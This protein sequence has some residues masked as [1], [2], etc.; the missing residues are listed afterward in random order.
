MA[1]SRLRA[2]GVEAGVALPAL[3]LAGG[4]VTGTFSSL[5]A[6]WPL[7]CLFPCCV[8]AGISWRFARP[9][10]TLIP[11]AAGF[12]AAG[13]AL[14]ADARHRAVHAPLRTLLHERFG[15]FAIETPGPA[16]DHDPVG[17][18]VLLT[19]DAA[20]RDGFVS[21]RG[22]VTAVEIDGGVHAV[23]GGASF[24][25]GGALAGARVPEWRAGR[26][27]RAWATFGRPARYLN[28]GVPD[29]ERGL[30]LD[31][32]TLFGSVKSGLLVDVVSRGSLL[33]EAAADARAHVRQVVARRVAPHDLVSAGIVTAVLIG[34][35]TGLPDDVRERLQKAG[36]YHVIAISGGNIA[37]LAAVALAA[38]ALL[39]VRGRAAAVLAIVVLLAYAQVVTAGPSVWRA[40]LMAVLYFTA[41]ALDHET[42]SWHVT[43]IAAGLM[44]TVEPLD[45]RDPGFILTFGATVALIEG[46][47]RGSAFGRRHRA[48]AWLLAS[49]AA[50]LATEAALLPVS[51]Q[52]FSR[53]TSAGVVLNLLAVP[54]MVVVQCAGMVAVFLDRFDAV[55]SAA[56]MV[57]YGAASALVGSARLVD[58]VPWLAVRVPPPG[59]VLL[60]VYYG[61]LVLVLSTRR[62][63]V[64]AAGAMMLAAA[65]L[66]IASGVRRPGPL[67]GQTER[68]VLRVTMFDVG[69]AEAMLLQLPDGRTLLVDAGGAPFGRGGF[70]IGARVLAP[71]LWA[72]GVRRLEAMLVTHGHPD[73]MGGARTLVEVFSPREL[74]EGVR[75]PED[76]PT[77]ELRDTA[78]RVGS[79]VVS[80]R[81]G[82]RVMSD[83]VG[84]RVLHPPEPDWERQRVRN[85]DSVVLE[86]LHGDVAF[87]LTGDVAS[88]VERSLLPHLARA[89]IRVLKVAHHGSRSST[90]RELIDQ[91]RPDVALISSG[92]GNTFGHPAPEVL[93]RLESAGATVLRTDLHGQIAVET[94][95]RSLRV[96]THTGVAT[97]IEGR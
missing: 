29:F 65:I 95:G 72:R 40:T 66:M 46:A 43:A 90:S 78:A 69:Q 49:M 33:E 1:S 73:H 10:L 60:L 31:G 5:A 79:A 63:A 45:V 77:Q 4:V 85:D 81:R 54:L 91:W 13:A 27:I 3:A 30:A 84:I 75:V 55:A 35:R 15:G 12:F 42:R 67:D 56:G 11:L 14:S 89:R 71:A 64:R 38:L 76:P 80:R 57:A 16:A 36:T 24:S 70:D 9:I 58:V 17:V 47:R 48:V 82:E 83:A 88:E 96:R 6:G 37:I 94:D 25:T 28:R 86:V 22:L 52:V 23:S 62:G 19:E 18:Y 61:S 41:R 92:R 68:S 50:S 7:W 97:E 59:A 2:S 87:L 8:A 39:G 20:P 53:V 44:L 26:T 32:T 21:L 93:R 74:W 51:A 34:D